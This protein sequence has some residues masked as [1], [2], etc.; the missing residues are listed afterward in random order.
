[1]KQ[2]FGQSVVPQSLARFAE[3]CGGVLRADSKQTCEIDLQRGEERVYALLE[4]IPANVG[5]A[6][7]SLHVAVIDITGRKW[8]VEELTRAKDAGNHPGAAF[9]VGLAMAHRQVGRL[10]RHKATKRAS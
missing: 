2:R 1:M 3:F 4:G 9:R 10:A 7:D 8:V 6:K 5:G